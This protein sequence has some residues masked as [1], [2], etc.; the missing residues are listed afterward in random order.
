MKA[1][2]FYYEDWTWLMID[3][4]HQLLLN[5]GVDDALKM[6]GCRYSQ[7]RNAWYTKRIITL[8]FI[9]Q[10]LEV[11]GVV[12]GT[13]PERDWD[14]H[15]SNSIPPDNFGIARRHGETV[16]QFV[17]RGLPYEEA[18]EEAKRMLGLIPNYDGGDDNVPSL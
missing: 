8:P 10:Y 3:E 18:L 1:I 11:V 7:G 14:Y 13:L 6:W 2:L 5:K 17:Q 9:D 15:K 4:Q 16:A 12:A